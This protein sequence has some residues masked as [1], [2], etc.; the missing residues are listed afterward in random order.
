MTIGSQTMAAGISQ[1][2][3]L[4]SLPLDLV[5]YVTGSPFNLIAISRLAKSLKCSGLFLDDLVFYIGMQYRVENCYR[6]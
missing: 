2:R 4:P 5:L 1:A 3:S 6:A